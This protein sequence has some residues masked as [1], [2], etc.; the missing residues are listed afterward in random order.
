[1]AKPDEW[2]SIEEYLHVLRTHVLAT[3]TYLA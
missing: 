1:M 2:V 3:A